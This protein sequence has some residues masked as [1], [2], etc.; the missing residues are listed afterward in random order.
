MFSHIGQTF[1]KLVCVPYESIMINSILETL[2]L[3][4]VFAQCNVLDFSKRHSD[5]VFSGPIELN[6]SEKKKMHCCKNIQK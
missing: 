4:S 3:L 2:Q 6:I 5:I 1:F